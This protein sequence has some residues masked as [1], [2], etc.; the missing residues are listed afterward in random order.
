MGKERPKFVRSVSPQ[1]LSVGS[2]DGIKLKEYVD[3]SS[4]SEV[5]VCSDVGHRF[6]SHNKVE[7]YPQKMVILNHS[8]KIHVHG[9]PDMEF[10]LTPV[11]GAVTK[12]G[13]IYQTTKLLTD[14]DYMD[15][16]KQFEKNTK[17]GVLKRKGRL[18]S[19]MFSDANHLNYEH[20]DGNMY[21]IL[22]NHYGAGVDA[23]FDNRMDRNNSVQIMK[24]QKFTLVASDHIPYDPY[25]VELMKKIKQQQL[26]QLNRVHS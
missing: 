14:A 20:D 26:Q 16:L 4:D 22:N 5:E 7:S 25:H 1:K 13:N 2:E 9:L 3:R 24:H 10:A 19:G 12:P 6:H 11:P 8:K 18:V 21:S 23:K 17:N 15:K